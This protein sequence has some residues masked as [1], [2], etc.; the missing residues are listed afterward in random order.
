MLL[1]R[2]LQWIKEKKYL[3]RRSRKQLQENKGYLPSL[4]TG[5]ACEDAPV[6]NGGRCRCEREIGLGLG[7]TATRARAASRARLRC[8]A[9]WVGGRPGGGWE[10]GE[11]ERELG[12]GLGVVH[13]FEKKDDQRRRMETR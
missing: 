13:G 1:A 12:H 4:V 3:Q 5:V 10:D 7:G 11:R 9:A 6:T 8:G 2:G